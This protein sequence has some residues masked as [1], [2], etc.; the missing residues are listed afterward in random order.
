ML[1]LMG[2]AS[3]EVHIEQQPEQNAEESR[4][5]TRVCSLLGGHGQEPIF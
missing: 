1:F 2:L 5:T 4:K 3:E